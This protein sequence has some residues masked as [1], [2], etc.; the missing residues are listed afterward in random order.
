MTDE[1]RWNEAKAKADSMAKAD[2]IAA[3]RAVPIAKRYP[4]LRFFEY[5]HLPDNLQEVSAPFA[6]LALRMA[7]AER[8]AETSA[9]LRKL[10]EAKDCAVRA[11]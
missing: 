6:A 2:S 3:G 9:G 5:S 4:I 1:E 8:N 10:L 11:L 7:Q